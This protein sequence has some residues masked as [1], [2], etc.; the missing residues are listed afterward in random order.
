LLAS[1]AEERRTECWWFVLE[2][3]TP[4]AGDGGGLVPLLTTVGLTRPVGHVLGWLRLSP[5]LDLLD[6]VLSRSRGQLSRLVPDGP[7]PRRYP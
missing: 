5:V 3:G 2:D 4:V 6:K 7:A 1:V